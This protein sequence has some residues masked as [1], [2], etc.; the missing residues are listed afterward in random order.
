MNINEIKKI[1]KLHQKRLAGKAGGVSA[2]L[3]R[4]NLS[5]ADLSSIKQRA[6]VIT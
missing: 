4:A 5:G 2:D 1:L 3:S 6:I